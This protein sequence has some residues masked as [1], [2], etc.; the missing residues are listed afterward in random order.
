MSDTC[1]ES[2]TQKTIDDFGA[3]WT[4]YR[5]NEGY[6][7]SLPLFEDILGGLL[8]INDL[9][10]KK[11][12]DI[13][14]GTGRIVNMILDADAASVTAIEP[15]GAFDVLKINTEARKE[16]IEYLKCRGDEIPP[17]AGYDYVFSI[18]VLHHI[19][20]P[21]PV[22]DA[23]FKSLKKGGKC[24]IW[25]YGYE[26]NELYL[27]LVLPLRKITSKMPDFILS[28]LSGILTFALS[29]YM[30]ACKILPLPM[31]A[32]M[33]DHIAKLSWKV[34]YLT[35]FDQLNPA[36]ARYYKKE[37]AIKLLENS[38]FKDV[39]VHHRHGYSWTV[40]GTKE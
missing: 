6:Y 26:G 35:I 2:V 18:G 19:P 33:L 24:L 25:L 39:K 1:T 32:Y 30:Y 20:D 36:E 29:L 23:A 4:T 3:Q 14:S 31:K 16:K 7:A 21:V 34:R 28:M 27:S 10:G 5:E 12:A 11:A 9:K 37:E 38:G 15:S 40:I 22:V 8:D 17:D 13:G